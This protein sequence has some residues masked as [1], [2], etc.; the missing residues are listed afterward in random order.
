VRAHYTA[1]HMAETVEQIYRE[2]I[3]R[4]QAAAV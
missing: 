1:G 4:Q 3:D 2:T